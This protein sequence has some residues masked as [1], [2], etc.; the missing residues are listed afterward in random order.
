MTR[1]MTTRGLWRDVPKW[2]R[3]DMT[4]CVAAACVED[5]QHYRIVIGVDWLVSGALGSADKMI[6]IR[7]V[8]RG[9]SC[10]T[11]GNEGDINNTLPLIRGSIIQVEEVD[12]TNIVHIVRSALNARKKEKID[13][14][15][16]GRYGISYD[17]FILFGKDKFPADVH[18]EAILT[19]SEITLGCVFI[20]VGF[21]SGRF[22]ILVETGEKCEVH[23]REDFATI[24]D[25]AYLA[26]SVMLQRKHMDIMELGRTIYT[27]YEAKK[28]AEGVSSVG[29]STT[30]RVLY[31]DGSKKDMYG[32]GGMDELEA[33]FEKYGPQTIPPEIESIK[34]YLED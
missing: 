11:A 3:R 6:K 26:Q 24:G 18:R 5:R 20:V 7:D 14:F 9:W 33:R 30:I 25:G 28:Y 13:E 32:L 1:V 29:T 21:Q 22:P 23:I 4:V 27:V 17:D 16:Q 10:L 15:I 12:E 19:F 2:E 34:K 31:P 8:G